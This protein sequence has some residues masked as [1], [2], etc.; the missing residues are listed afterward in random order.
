MISGQNKVLIGR[1]GGLTDLINTSND[2]MCSGFCFNW[3]RG[4]Q[5]R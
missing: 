4:C 2:P 1:F 3:A 5:Q